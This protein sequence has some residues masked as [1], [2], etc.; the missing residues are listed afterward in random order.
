MNRRY[1]FKSLATVAGA[2]SVAPLIFIP[3]FEPVRW[4][5]SALTQQMLDEATAAFDAPVPGTDKSVM[6]ILF[7]GTWQWKVVGGDYKLFQPTL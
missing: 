1:F 7:W 2:T 6:S 3:K 5:R 4:K